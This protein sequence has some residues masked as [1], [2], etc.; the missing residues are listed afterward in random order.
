[1]RLPRVSSAWALALLVLP[2]AASAQTSSAGPS[3]DFAL[4]LRGARVFT[5]TKGV[6]DDA[7]VLVHRGKFT[8]V[9]DKD[10]RVNLPSTRYQEVDLRGKVLFPGIVD[11]HTHVGITTKPRV[12]ANSDGNEGS[13]P[14]QPG[15]RA[16]DAISPSDPGIKMALAGGVTTANI[17][18]GSGTLMGGQTAYVKFRG[19]SIEEM[20]IQKSGVRGGLKMANGENPKRSFGPRKVSP[21]TRMAVTALQRA[22]FTKAKRYKES[23]DR[24]RVLLENGRAQ[25]SDGPKREFRLDPL[26]EV[27]AR[28]RTV[29]F[30]THRADD[31]LT[32][33]RLRKEFGI[34]VVLHHVSEG[35]KVAREIAE[36]KVPCSIIVIDSPG[37]K[38]E[39]ADFNLE[40]GGVLERAGVKVAIH[41]DDFITSSR[42]MFRMAGLLVREGM[43][44]E[45]ALRA[46]TIH[47]AEMLDLEKRVGSIEKGKD[48]DFVVLSGDPLDVDT[49]VLETWIEGERVFSRKHDRAYAIGGFAVGDRL[50]LLRDSKS[51]KLGGIAADAER[52]SKQASGKVPAGRSRDGDE[53]GEAA[54]RSRKGA[55]A[56]IDPSK[57][58]VVRADKL[59]TM[60]PKGVI[61]DGYVLV[62]RGKI[63]EVGDAEAAKLHADK[64]ALRAAIVTPGLVD[65]RS[66]VG[67]AGLF[68]VPADQDQDETAG[69]VQPQLR[70]TDAFNPREKLLRYL[71]RHGV[72]TVQSGPGEANV[73]AGQAGVF[74]TAGR[75]LDEAL[76]RF[77]SMLICNLGEAP[78]R[79]YAETR[80]APMT[81]MATA[82]LLREQ[83]QKATAQA[84]KLE[85]WESAARAGR[86]SNAERPQTDLDL[87][88]LAPYALGKLPI[89]ITA[90]RE[91]DIRTALRIGQEFGLRLV[92][93]HATEGYLMAKELAAAKV[94]VI[95]APPMQRVGSRHETLNSSYE[96]AAVLA[97]SGVR[98]GFASGFESYVPKT[99]V[100]LF[101]A[102]VAAANGLGFERS[103]R[104][105]TIDAAR[106][107]GVADRV[108]SLEVGKDADLV[109]F[110]G[111]PFQATSHVDAVIA[112][113][114]LAFRR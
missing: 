102:S 108:G 38:H 89:L 3:D 49:K 76:V 16:L 19:G 7:V 32:V 58:F 59:V 28:Q 11:T 79:T 45:A 70:A 105:A 98:V 114:R 107:L 91:D 34:K 64:P 27:L 90:H 99:R 65:A 1:M 51:A 74:K 97:V 46:L 106:I 56:A 37:G 82:A 66:V 50:P 8:L 22:I 112:N 67:L 60:G 31:I 2:A 71:L 86:A 109:L 100:L 44:R 35:Y 88:A 77:P 80:K 6:I 63:R 12:S 113:G 42:Q 84:R 73:I 5:I 57:A 47:G 9:G 103:M 110:D 4:I 25:A 36:A 43:S 41:S 93:D 14:L 18:P 23:V 61:D 75:T 33:L 87:E 92:L 20:L 68:N 26:V 101:E 21:I 40:Y 111:E 72:T 81:R 83:L 29:H 54:R 94:P 55:I 96:N 48:A 13:A 95:V 10:A 17:M 30:H 15:L 69:P 85:V 78:K 39:A 104:A 53:H 52:A 62:E 24:H